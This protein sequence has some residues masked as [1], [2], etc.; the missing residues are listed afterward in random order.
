MSLRRPTP[1][2]PGCAPPACPRSSR[3]GTSRY[4][5]AALALSAAESGQ[6]VAISTP[7][8]CERRL[9]EG[10]LVRPFREVLRS[11]ETYHFV[12]RPAELGDRRIAALRDWLVERLAATVAPD[13]SANAK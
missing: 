13:T 7:I 9:R 10:K 2:R 6:G 5:H 1:G 3:A 11:S 4:D 8:L 12:C